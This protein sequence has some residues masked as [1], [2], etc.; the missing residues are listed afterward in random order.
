MSDAKIASVSRLFQSA[1]MK[2]N[3]EC[4]IRYSSVG[5]NLDSRVLLEAGSS[6]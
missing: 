4:R 2:L 1:V 6:T 5:T 3:L